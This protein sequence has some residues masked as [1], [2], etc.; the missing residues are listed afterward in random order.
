M[1]VEAEMTFRRILFAT[2]FSPASRAAFRVAVQLARRERGRLVIA[3]VLPS[4]VS[5]GVETYVSARMYEEMETSARRWAQKRLDSL[6]EQAR[7]SRVAARTVLLAGAADE[8][9]SSAAAKERADLIVIGTH[10]RTGLERVFMGSVA[11]RIIGT[12]PCPVL[13]IRPRRSSKR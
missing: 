2:D 11:A 7:R 5:L 1:A 8:G 3:H 4:V 12:A 10:G 6:V 9:V 13:T